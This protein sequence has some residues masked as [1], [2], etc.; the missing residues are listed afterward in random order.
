MEAA[1]HFASVEK[2]GPVSSL[3]QRAP[4]QARPSSNVVEIAVV[5]CMLIHIHILY[6]SLIFFFFLFFFLGES[7]RGNFVLA[8][9]YYTCIIMDKR[10]EID[11]QVPKVIEITYNQALLTYTQSLKK[12]KNLNLKSTPS[13]FIS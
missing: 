4:M 6:L 10:S 11:Y 1:R 13:T 2:G 9:C 3:E 7:I 5:L 12:L 8:F